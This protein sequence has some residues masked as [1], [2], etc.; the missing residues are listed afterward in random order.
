MVVLLSGPLP[1]PVSLAED[2]PVAGS[3]EE[4]SE[5]TGGGPALWVDNGV[6]PPF[7]A[8]FVWVMKVVDGPNSRYARHPDLVPVVTGL[9]FH[10]AGGLR[11]AT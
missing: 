11:E 9:M 6:A 5:V 10:V 7:D 2:F 8:V 3:L 1:A 4:A